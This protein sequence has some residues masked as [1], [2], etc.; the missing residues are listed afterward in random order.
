[1]RHRIHRNSGIVR[2][3]S[4]LLAIYSCSS[5]PKAEELSE[6]FDSTPDVQNC[7][8][9]CDGI[10]KVCWEEACAA[11]GPYDERTGV[12][13]LGYKTAACEDN[14]YQLFEK[15]CGRKFY[16]DH[17]SFKCCCTDMVEVLDETPDTPKIRSECFEVGAFK[18]CGDYCNSIGELCGGGCY[19]ATSM[20]GW[21]AEQACTD[22]DV[23]KTRAVYGCGD[24]F[25]VPAVSAQCCCTDRE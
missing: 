16:A 12:T 19:N 8:E 25:P 1:M 13:Y 9:Y 17:L 6:C 18:H 14:N 11:G 2:L 15:S 10:D 20:G 4:L 3:V 23:G 21:S 22:I 5:E 7:W 24:E